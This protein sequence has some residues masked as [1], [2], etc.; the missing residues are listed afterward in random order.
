M[1]L[2]Q[3]RFKLNEKQTIKNG[4]TSFSDY[5]VKEVKLH[6]SFVDIVVTS[7]LPSFFEKIYAYTQ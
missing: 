5:T 7:L 3:R 4:Q 6:F 2:S 1:D